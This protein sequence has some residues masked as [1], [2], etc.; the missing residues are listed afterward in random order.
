VLDRLRGRYES[1]RRIHEHTDPIMAQFLAVLAEREA[2]T[3]AALDRYRVRDEHH[4]ALDVQIRLGHGFPYV[5]DA[6]EL[7]NNPSFDELIEVAETTD[8]ELAQLSERIQ[9]YA[10]S[11]ELVA[12]LE[13]IEELVTERRRTLAGTTQELED[14]APS[15]RRLA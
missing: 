8:T 15:G 10:V 11:P 1:L 2:Q 7:P 4:A 6:L 3:I 12:A 9:V 5:A 14:Y 13:S